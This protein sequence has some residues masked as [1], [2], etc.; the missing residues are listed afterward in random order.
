MTV[1]V[2]AS[3]CERWLFWCPGC[4][5]AHQVSDKWD[6]IDVEAGTISPSVLVQGA[7]EHGR[8]VCHSFVTAGRIQFL[9]DCTHG[10]AG[11]TVDLPDFREA[12]S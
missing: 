8:T 2:K 1:I 3:N 7:N 5:E 4:D 11:Q 10:L 6:V 12:E 9:D